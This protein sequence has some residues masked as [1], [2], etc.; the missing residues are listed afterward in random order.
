MGSRLE[1][2]TQKWLGKLE[3]ILD[4]L[5]GLKSESERARRRDFGGLTLK[6]SEMTV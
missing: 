1:N 4:A 2:K 5:M 6:I 3:K